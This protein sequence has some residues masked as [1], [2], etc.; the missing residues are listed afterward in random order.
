[1]SDRELGKKMIEE[2]ELLS[3]FEAY[4]E[5]VEEYLSCSFR[6]YERPDFILNGGAQ[7]R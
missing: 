2:E 3:F 4:K 1:M 5:K 7:A 6:R